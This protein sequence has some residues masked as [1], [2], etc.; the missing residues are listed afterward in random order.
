MKMRLFVAIL[1]LIAMAAAGP[2]PAYAASDSR[3]SP[4]GTAVSQPQPVMGEAVVAAAMKLKGTPY[5]FGGTTPKAFDCSGFV[6]YVFDQQGIRLPRTAD[7]Q[8]ETG[9]T[10]AVRELQPGDVVFFTTYE[11]GASHCGIY[12]GQGKFVHASSSRGVSVA[13]LADSY[14]KARY[15]G[16]RRML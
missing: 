15:L 4:D 16:A 14:W 6:W 11:K 9:R 2:A 10:V 8:F 1:I 5:R 3:T 13:G 7:R 12:I